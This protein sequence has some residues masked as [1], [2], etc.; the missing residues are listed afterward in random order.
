MDIKDAVLNVMGTSFFGNLVTLI[1]GLFGKAKNPL[2]P[3]H[4]F[5][6]NYLHI[7]ISSSVSNGTCGILIRR[8][9]MI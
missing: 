6:K 1:V 9:P 8:L 7:L 2:S 4:I 5:L 3:A